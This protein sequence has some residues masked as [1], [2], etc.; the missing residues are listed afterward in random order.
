MVINRPAP[1][2]FRLQQTSVNRSLKMH[3][4]MLKKTFCTSWCKKYFRW[5]WFCSLPDL[6]FTFFCNVSA[7]QW[8]ME[9]ILDNGVGLSNIEIT[10]TRNFT[11]RS[12]PNC[13]QIIENYAKDYTSGL[14]QKF[15]MWAKILPLS[16]LSAVHPILATV[17]PGQNLLFQRNDGL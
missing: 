15:Y 8:L 14:L 3:H 1:T 13:A 17:A 4:L 7:D 9:S 5:S 11:N 6:F 2:I 10:E 16:T 12:F